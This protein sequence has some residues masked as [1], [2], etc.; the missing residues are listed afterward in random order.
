LIYYFVEDLLLNVL[1]PNGRY[2]GQKLIKLVAMK[3]PASASSTMATV[4]EMMLVKY[5]AMIAI[6]ASERITLSRVPMF[7]FIVFVGVVNSVKINDGKRL[8]CD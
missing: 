8:V 3:I 1:S 5:N 2:S 6:A 7:A 4:P